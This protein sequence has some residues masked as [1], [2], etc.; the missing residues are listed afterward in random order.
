MR[1][2]ARGRPFSVA[3]ANVSLDWV[4]QCSGDEAATRRQVRNPEEWNSVLKPQL[5]D[6]VLEIGR[7]GY[8]DV[9]IRG[10]MRLP[11]AFAVGHHFSDLAGFTV[12]GR[13]RGDDWSSAGDVPAVDVTRTDVPLALGADLAVGVSV[14]NDLSADVEAYLRTAGIPVSRL[15]HLMPGAGVGHHSVPD[16]ATAR[17]LARQIVTA[18][19]EAVRETSPPRNSSVSL[20]AACSCARPW[21]HLEPDPRNDCLR[22][23][24]RRA[25]RAGLRPGLGR[26]PGRRKE[27]VLGPPLAGR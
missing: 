1:E 7:Q 18:V 3:T 10:L 9:L 13:Q 11:I 4:D 23:P 2:V 19:R 20:Y 16:D 21:A 14:A 22:G 15:V 27:P 12:A 5:R 24:P 26:S 25:L 17:G 8:D 6:A